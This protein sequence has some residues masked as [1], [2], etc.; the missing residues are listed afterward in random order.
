MLDTPVRSRH[1]NK[2]K[3]TVRRTW[4]ELRLDGKATLVT[5]ASSGIGQGIAKLFAEAGADVTVVYR[6]D[7]AGAEETAE[8][9]RKSGRSALVHQ[10][11]VGDAGEAA[12]LFDAHLAAFGK[13][14]VLVNNAGIG[15]G[16]F[17]HELA[18]EDWER[19][20]RTNLYGP[21]FC[22]QLAARSMI[23]AGNGGRII[24]ISSVHEEACT[25]GS[26]PYNV[27][28]AGLRNLTRTQAAELGPYGITVNDIAPGMIV[29]Q[30][31]NSRAYHDEEYRNNAASHIV[32]RRAGLPSDIAAMAL[33]L[34]SDAGSYCTGSTHFVDGGWML[35]WPP[36]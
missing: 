25:P 8:A 11:D 3:P 21:F 14:D 17:V 34:A 18:H 23:A 24:N 33:F 31:L 1:R 35:T 36:V 28:K 26:A 2:S 9:I 30:G 4:V 22:S 27:S 6:R 29:T 7:P 5:G 10:A 19:V 16:G 32:A 13:I 15:A 20:L 12:R